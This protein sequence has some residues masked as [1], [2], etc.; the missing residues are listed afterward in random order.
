MIRWAA[1][2]AGLL[3]ASFPS[4]KHPGKFAARFDGRTLAGV[5]FSGERDSYKWWIVRLKYR[6]VRNNRLIPCLSSPSPAASQPGKSTFTRL[7]GAALP[8]AIFDTDQ[9]ARALLADNGE[10]AQSVKAAFGAEVFD[11]EG[12][13]DRGI[14]RRIVFGSKESRKELETILHP[15]VRAIWTRWAHDEL[16]NAPEAILLVEIPL[17]YEIAAASL[18]D[19]VIVVGCA[20]ETQLLR[21]T[22]ERRLS[23][24]IA[25]QII[26]SQWPL[27]E[28]LRLGDHLIW[29]DGSSAGL[30]MQ[31]DFCRTLPSS[32]LPSTACLDVTLPLALPLRWEI[33][34]AEHFEATGSVFASFLSIHDLSP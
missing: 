13:I 6:G 32:Y 2:P 16:Q 17:L 24:D 29:N 25:R 8:A 15:R 34:F 18:F 12:K 21:L 4:Y 22:S 27:T 14:L 5:S 19:Q 28:K 7:L 33:R 9:C 3:E 30:Q 20:Q 31:S 10:V 26:A 23:N 11:A 1:P